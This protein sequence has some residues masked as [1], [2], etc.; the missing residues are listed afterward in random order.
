M[1]RK[2]HNKSQHNRRTVHG[3]FDKSKPK[4]RAR[5]KGKRSQANYQFKKTEKQEKLQRLLGEYFQRKQDAT[6]TVGIG[7]AKALYNKSLAAFSKKNYGRGVYML[8]LASAIIATYV[9]HHMPDTTG[10]NGKTIDD[11]KGYLEHNYDMATN[12]NDYEWKNDG[13]VQNA[14][15]EIAE[16]DEKVAAQQDDKERLVSSK[17]LL[18]EKLEKSNKDNKKENSG[19]CD[20]FKCSVQGGGAN[21]PWGPST[22]KWVKGTNDVTIEHLLDEI[23]AGKPSPLS[24]FKVTNG[25]AK[26][27]KKKKEKGTPEEQQ[28][29]LSKDEE[30]AVAAA[31]ASPFIVKRKTQSD[32]FSK[33][34]PMWARNYLY[35]RQFDG[36]EN[37]GDKVWIVPS[38]FIDPIDVWKSTNKLYNLLKKPGVM[39]GLFIKGHK[40]EWKLF[41]DKNKDFGFPFLDEARDAI[42]KLKIFDTDKNKKCFTEKDLNQPHWI[43]CEKECFDVVNHL[44]KS[45]IH[46]TAFMLRL[47]T[48]SLLTNNPKARIKFKFI[49][50]IDT[51]IT[52][53][54]KADKDKF[55]LLPLEPGPD[56]G[57][58]RPDPRLIMCYGPSA[59]GKTFN[60]KKVL[61]LLRIGHPTFPTA[62]VAIDGG[63]AREMS[64]IYQM[65]V[66]KIHSVD[67]QMSGF[68]NLVS[69]GLSFSKSLF[70]SEPKKRLQEFLK[71]QCKKRGYISLY[72]PTT[73]TGELTQAASLKK[74]QKISKWE[75][76]KDERWIG[77]M[78]YQ[79]RTHA[80]C[81]FKHEFKCMGCTESGRKREIGEGKEYSNSAFQMAFDHGEYCIKHAPGGRIKIHNS[82]GFKHNGKFTASIVTEYPSRAMQR[83]T[84]TDQFLFNGYTKEEWKSNNMVYFKNDKKVCLLA[85]DVDVPWDQDNPEPK[86]LTD[87]FFKCMPPNCRK[88]GSKHTRGKK[89]KHKRKHKKTKRK[90]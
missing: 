82:G 8:I 76:L 4:L 88:G 85:K 25:G 14:I 15:K 39:R 60:A 64:A 3:T 79:H 44:I 75:G 5:S 42:N 2:S 63:I 66:N 45:E 30:A 81:P 36:G 58:G 28:P 80:E 73:A 52:G 1:P 55:E 69:A 49:G 37:P 38:K 16:D 26:K 51:D 57:G 35:G 54:W 21:T 10:F 62:F 17:D 34:P 67:N 61:Q 56:Q 23:A 46:S 89:N 72:I 50:N 48:N 12:V 65:V 31:V 29:L 78:I 87:K 74:A 32:E 19:M 40:G 70:S 77:L 20:N 11:I 43:K 24:D 90:R 7:K 59:A 53:L 9:P 22:F 68:S 86:T 13:E 33:N 83:G 18:L 71:E 84:R 6:N 41:D 47:I 27:K